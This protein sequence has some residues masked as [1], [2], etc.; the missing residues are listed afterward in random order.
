MAHPQRRPAPLVL[1]V[2]LAVFVVLLQALL[3]PLFAAPAARSA[4][5]DLPVIVA[6][7][8][9]AAAALRQQLQAAAPGAFDVIEE[10]DAHAADAALRDRTAY[11]AFLPGPDGLTL[12]V[13][14]AASPTVAQLLSSAA[15]ELAARQGQQ[16]SIVDVVP[17]DPDD[18]HGAGFAAGFLP[19][20]V[21]SMIAG[22]LFG[23]VVRGRRAR[24]AG[25]VVYAA[26]AGLVGA[27]VLR[28]WLGVLPGGFLADAG[29]IALFAL[30]ASA[31]VAG[32]TVLF[33]RIGARSASAAA[34]L[35]AVGPTT[36]AG[37]VP[38]PAGTAT[39]AGVIPPP[40]GDAPTTPAEA[41]LPPAGDAPA[42]PAAIARSGAAPVGAALGA[43]LVFFAGNPLS[44]VS[45]APELLPAPWG[46]LG[47]WLP[48]GAG[49][50]LLRAV[51][52]FDGARSAG[53]A[54]I[55]TGYALVGLALVGL[56]QRVRPAV[57]SAPTVT[58]SGD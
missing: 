41:T 20:T 23:L 14:S 48:T 7:P 18:P 54:L 57:T 44:G 42:A 16:I 31:A 52:Y 9:P 1:A 2:T 26:L 22:I 4:P 21:T 11:A 47:Q 49:G 56:A 35:P 39:P 27:A 53:A 38:P 55:L 33:G 17:L 40:A 51:A 36:P 43:V 29:A 46:A 37:A 58:Q 32:L 3:V 34:T 25:I 12:H 30:A 50:T 45:A 6:G 15:T 10:P 13:A 24:L 8:A 5:R 19:F 28:G